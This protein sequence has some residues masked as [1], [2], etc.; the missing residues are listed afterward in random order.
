M[1]DQKYF[2]ER[3]ARKTAALSPESR[4]LAEASEKMDFTTEDAAPAQLLNEIIW[5][6]VKGDASPMPV[7]K[8]TNL[9]S[10]TRAHD[11]DDDD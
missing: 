8:T 7:P 10:L 5:K 11:K 9:L 6:S 3:N 1:P 2:L 4:R